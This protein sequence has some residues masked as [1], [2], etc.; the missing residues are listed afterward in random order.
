MKKIAI[1]GAGVVGLSTLVHFPD[2]EITVFEK[3]ESLL[4]NI[5][6]KLGEVFNHNIDQRRLNVTTKHTDNLDVTEQFDVY[7]ICVPTNLHQTYR[8]LDTSII[9]ECLNKLPQNATVIIRS[10]VPI[11][12]F[13]E[14]Q[15]RFPKMKFGYIPEFLREEFIHYDT[16]SLHDNGDLVYSG[17]FPA[18]VIDAL[19]FFYSKKAVMV[20]LREAEIIKLAHN[21]AISARLAYF[22][23]INRYCKENDI[24]GEKIINIVTNHK[25]IGKEY[26]K[27]PFKIG[28]KCLPKDIITLASAFKSN[29]LNSIVNLINK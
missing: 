23:E 10:T 12:Y 20:S 7:F 13:E 22:S 28:G 6:Q 8:T 5:H 15:P 14:T 18:T 16:F 17:S 26:S 27:P 1:I 19:S 4:E 29:F 11:G 21:G 9:E 24:D 25:R 2:Y 3:D